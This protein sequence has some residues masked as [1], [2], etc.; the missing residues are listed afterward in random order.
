MRKHHTTAGIPAPQ[1]LEEA[2]GDICSCI[3]FSSVPGGASAFLCLIFLLRLPITAAMCR[4]R[5]PDG[6]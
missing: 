1:S 3:S 6:G 2:D 5:K 4:N